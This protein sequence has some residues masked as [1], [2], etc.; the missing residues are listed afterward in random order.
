[1]IESEKIVHTVP[2]HRSKLN[3]TQWFANADG[4]QYDF[5]T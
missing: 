3:I 5:R 1:M 2:G 4:F